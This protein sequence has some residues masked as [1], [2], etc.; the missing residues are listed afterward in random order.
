MNRLKLDFTI[1]DSVE[2]KKFLDEYL[3]RIKFTPNEEELELMANYILWGRDPNLDDSANPKT[4]EKKST[5]AAQNGIEIQ[6]R[7]KTWD[8]KNKTESLDALIEAPTFNEAL[9]TTDPTPYTTTK[10]NFSRAKARLEAPAPILEILEDLWLQI[11]KLELLLNLY[12]LRTGKRKEKPREQLLNRFTPAEQKNL[13]EKST[14][15]NPYTYLKKRHELVELR[16]QQFTY[17]DFYA[18]TLPFS[19]PTPNLNQNQTLTYDY[20]IKVRPLGL[21]YKDNKFSNLI[22]KENFDPAQYTS[23]ELNQISQFYWTNKAENDLPPSTLTIDFR[24]LEDVYQVIL[25][26]NELADYARRQ[27]EE[28]NIED[29]TQALLDTLEFYISFAE[30]TPLQRDI[31]RFKIEGKKNQ[32]IQHYINQT[33]KKTYTVN[34]ISTIFRQKIIKQINEAAQYHFEVIGNLFFPENFRKCNFCGRTLLL[35]SR[36]FVHKSKSSTGF[37]SKCKSCEKERRLLKKKE[38]EKL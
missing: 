1:L 3:Q 21:Y 24:N 28:H 12:D 37:N 6:T 31:L 25:F 26:Y 14:H 18:P 35:H 7:H 19:A 10:A 15:L 22:F 11:D 16:K 36:N 30:L 13:Y 33:Y 20:D 29:T 4:Y 2:R 34:Y 5:L 9:L 17:K 8:T 38:K 27:K 23:T 32:E